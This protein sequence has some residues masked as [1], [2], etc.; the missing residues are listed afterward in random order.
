MQWRPTLGAW[1]EPRGVSFRVW[2]PEAKAVRV[3]SSRPAR[4]RVARE[5]FS[6]ARSE[7][8][9]QDA[10]VGDR[11]RYEVDGGNALSRPCLPFSARGRSR[12]FGDR[13]PPR[14]RLDRQ[15]WTGI[16]RND[17]VLYELH[18]GTF[19]PEG[20]FAAATRQLP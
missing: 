10:K 7:P 18:V 6:T 11:Y 16:P 14:I 9:V 1:P 8:L 3:S 5:R 4:L 19:T 15:G 17:L 13:R 2:A 12:P 20:T